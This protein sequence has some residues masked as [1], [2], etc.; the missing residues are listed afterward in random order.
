MR[1]SL[2]CV[3]ASLVM[4]LGFSLMA[5]AQAG[6]GRGPAAQTPH[7][8][9]KFYATDRP[10]GDGGP[11]PKR[12]LT[13]TWGGPSSGMAVPRATLAGGGFNNPEDPKPPAYTPLGQKTF[14]LNKPI[15]KYSP[16]G[17]NDP[18]TRYCDPLGVP[19]NMTN[20][21]RG[22]QIATMPNKVI[23]M[24]QYMD[25]WRE[26]WTDGRALPTGVGSSAKGSLA[27]KYNGYSVGHWEDDYN[28]VV[29]TVG[30]EPTT[31]ATKGGQPHS[32][33]T[34][35]TE[36]F[37]RVD[38]NDMQLS[39]TMTD[40]AYYTAPFVIG[41][42]N[43]RWVPNQ[44]LDDFTCIPSEV[45]EYLKTMADPAGFD[46]NAPEPGRGGRGGRGR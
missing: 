28:F 38:K 4:L 20:E 33:D 18:H 8:P 3:I 21:I 10:V 34:K 5:R 26:I 37:T 43:F 25:V 35:V 45:Q 1:K 36:R 15:G 6:G 32:G 42:E 13:G 12:D 2:T 30:L 41:T 44:Q 14:D 16:A 24:I 9:W 31:W 7:S 39:I 23:L 11:A 46:A 27:P 22:L 29:E 40:P 19:Q 17:T